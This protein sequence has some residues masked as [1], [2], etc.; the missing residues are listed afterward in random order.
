MVL[1]S[2]LTVIAGVHLIHAITA[3]QHQMAVDLWT[4][5]TDLSNKP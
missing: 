3:E 1:S 2:Q 4:K 5:P